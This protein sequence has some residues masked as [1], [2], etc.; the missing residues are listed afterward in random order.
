MVGLP[1][2]IRPSFTLGGTGGG[3]AFNREEFFDIVQAGTKPTCATNSADR[4]RCSAERIRRSRSCA[5]KADN[6]I[7][8]GQLDWCRSGGRTQAFADDSATR[9]TTKYQH[10]HWRQPR[11]DACRSASDKRG[12]NNASYD[13]QQRGH[14]RGVSRSSSVITLIETLAIRRG[15]R[16]S[17]A[18]GSRR[19]R[20]RTALE[21]AHPATS[22]ALRDA[23][24]SVQ[25]PPHRLRGATKNPALHD[26]EG[27]SG[28]QN[29]VNHSQMKSGR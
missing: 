16:F 19:A 10:I 27:N 5:N 14:H 15:D 4:D 24:A 23:G 26:S 6:A 9:R 7:I 1:A 18:R 29:I 22:S 21:R 11:S 17:I 25:T 28:R 8:D 12:S 20:D 2:V 13:E 3:I